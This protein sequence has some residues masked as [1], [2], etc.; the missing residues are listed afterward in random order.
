MIRL[1]L[2]KKYYLLTKPGI[3]RGNAIT[4]LAG[5]LLASKGDVDTWL[6]LATITGISLVMASGCVFNNYIDR[7]IDSKM[8]RTKNRALVI[9]SVPV[10]DALIYASLLAV[11]GF[12]LLGVFTNLTTV[13]VGIVGFVDYIVLYGIAKRRSVHGTLVGSISGATPPV[14][15]YVAVTNS[16]DFGATILFAVLVFWQMP[17]FYA[18]AIR[19]IDDYK[20]AKIPVLPIKNGMK[21]TKI[22]IYIYILAFIIS[23]SLL[24]V[25]G[26]TGLTYLV[27]MVSAGLYWLWIASKGFESKDDK[28]WAKSIFIFSLKVLMLFSI[29]ISI[30]VFIP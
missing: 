11:L 10:K 21:H 12:T 30:D 2:L 16:F 13:I 18:I 23:S 5:F 27:V 1:G 8:T 26:Y 17:H 7:N 14:A 24:T 15:G 6:L 20:K 28:L 19:R 29:M 22:Q 3:I 9:Q 25:A 4:A